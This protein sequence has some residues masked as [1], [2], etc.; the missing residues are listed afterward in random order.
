M[1]ND[2][3]IQIEKLD[4]KLDFIIQE[5]NK[6]KQ[7]RQ[8]FDDLIADASIIG[9]DFF[10]TAVEKFDMAGIEFDYQAFEKFGLKLLKNFK[11]FNELLQFIESTNDLLKDL[12]PIIKQI[13]LDIADKLYEIEKKGY[14]DFIK[15][16]AKIFD[17][18]VTNF[19]LDDIRLLSDNIV[20]I[21]QT[22]KNL[23]Q[24]DMLKSINNAVE[25]FK[26]INTDNIPEYSLWKVFKEINSKDG[27]RAIGFVFTFLK[28]IGS[29]NENIDNKLNEKEQ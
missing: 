1:A 26:N 12:S 2:K 15:E 20:T 23:T 8:A 29:T 27:R 9:K 22:I 19:S 18:I 28:N 4:N 5:I 11:T 21:F 10:S 16:T 24:P 3:N 14:I 7:K 6:Q 17:N 13:G 25:I